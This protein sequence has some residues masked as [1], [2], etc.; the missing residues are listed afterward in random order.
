MT[1]RVGWGVSFTA[2]EFARAASAGG[3]DDTRSTRFI[4]YGTGRARRRNDAVRRDGKLIH[5]ACLFAIFRQHKTEVHPWRCSP[6]EALDTDQIRI[7]LTNHRFGN[8]TASLWHKSTD[9]MNGRSLQVQSRWALARDE[10]FNPS[11]TAVA[12]RALCSLS[13]TPSSSPS[14]ARR[15]SIIQWCSVDDSCQRCGS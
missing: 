4:R 10:A 5:S 7:V 15:D 2:G 6:S 9:C 8:Q 12:V 1:G 14:R 11:T 13:R 3:R